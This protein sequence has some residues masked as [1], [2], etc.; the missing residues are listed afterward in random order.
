MGTTGSRRQQR[1]VSLIEGMVATVVLLT[2]LVGVLQGLIV[3]VQQNAYA[4]RM[5][6]ASALA[7]TTVMRMQSMGRARLVVA[8]GPLGSTPC[9]TRASMTAAQKALTGPMWAAQNAGGTL[10]ACFVDLDAFDAAAADD[11]TRTLPREMADELRIFRRVGLYF[12]DS[13]TTVSAG[14]LTVVVSWSG[15]GRTNYARQSTAL[16]DPTTNQTNVEY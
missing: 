7:R 8:A 5:T 13:D 10:S 9:I 3:A 14:T 2:S 11:T 4:N 6:Q 1:G 16:Y 15:L 12:T